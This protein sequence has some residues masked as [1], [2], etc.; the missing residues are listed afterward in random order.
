MPREIERKYLVLGDAWRGATASSR[1]IRQGYLSL[2]P[3]RIVRVRASDD[4]AHIAVKGTTAGVTR[5]EYEYEIPLDHARELL[6]RMCIEP[7]IEKTRH[8]VDA[9]G[10]RWEID[11]F[12]GANAGLVVAEVEL[13]AAD[14]RIALPEWVGEEVSG[15]PRYFNAALVQSPWRGWGQSD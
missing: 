1:R 15:D 10:K 14:E 13:S 5:D 12:A 8:E 4:R 9:C 3:E 7:T 2:D 6:D 11:E